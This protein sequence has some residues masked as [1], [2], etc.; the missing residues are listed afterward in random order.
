VPWDAVG[1]DGEAELAQAGVTVRCLVRAD[2]SLPD[3]VD[4]PDLVAVV[5]RAY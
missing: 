5:A 2:G 4:D 1:V 3:A